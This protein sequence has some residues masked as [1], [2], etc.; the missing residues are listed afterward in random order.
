VAIQAVL[1]CL[2]NT[3]L[4]FKH[5]RLGYSVENLFQPC[6]SLFHQY[7]FKKL[8]GKL[9][10]KICIGCGEE[11]D[12]EQDFNWKY[13]ERGIRNTRCKY[14]QSELSKVHYRNNKQAY[15][16]RAHIR[17]VHVID[18]NRRR[19]ADYLS[20]HSCVD[21]G[22]ADVRV[23]EFDHVHGE[24]SGN[25]ARMVGEGYSWATIEAEIVKCEVRC[26]NCHRIRES[27]KNGSWRHFYD[28]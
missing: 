22:C 17:D 13:K 5:I 24:K 18:D 9:M 15:L 28:L 25:I 4:T 7:F 21:C 3:L 12:V 14:C 6:Y 11:R 26:A 20:A 23:L 10:K 2:H 8:G 1:F 19:I 27:K 16:A